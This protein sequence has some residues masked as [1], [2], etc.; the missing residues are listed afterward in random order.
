MRI[1]K[2]RKGSYF[3]SFLEP[4]RRIDQTLYAVVME[5]YV[6][7]VSTRS[8]N[9]LVAAK[10]RLKRSADLRNIGCSDPADRLSRY[11]P[12]AALYQP[13]PS[14]RAIWCSDSPAAGPTRIS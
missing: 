5:A 6:K 13:W 10:F 12:S 7:G 4:R 8:V 14:R 2:L 9:D 3:P 1:P 11:R